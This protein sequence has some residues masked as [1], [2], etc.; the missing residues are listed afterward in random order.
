MLHKLL[1]QTLRSQ[2]AHS[3]RRSGQHWNAQLKFCAGL[4]GGASA[5]SAE[6]GK[7]PNLS[8]PRARGA[9]EAVRTEPQAGRKSRTRTAN[10][11]Q[12]KGLGPP[13]YSAPPVWVQWRQSTR[14][15]SFL[16]R[17][18]GQVEFL[19]ALRIRNFAVWMLHSHV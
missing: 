17:G 6:G 4:R 9:E 15:P 2:D 12:T 11:G 13:S 7:V 16:S 18:S 5:G 3:A 19:D 1:N 8:R 10:L 14:A